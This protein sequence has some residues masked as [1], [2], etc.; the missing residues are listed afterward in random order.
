MLR[1]PWLRHA[2]GVYDHAVAG[3]VLGGIPEAEWTDDEAVDDTDA[4]GR[5]GG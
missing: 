5:R 4:G 1:R 3:D 2:I